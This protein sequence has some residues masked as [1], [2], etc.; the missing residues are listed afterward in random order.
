M[1]NTTEDLLLKDFHNVM[2]CDI[3]SA[4]NESAVHCQ[5][6]LQKAELSEETKAQ[7]PLQ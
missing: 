1:K 4:T 7:V 2:K 5:M 6:I 3:E